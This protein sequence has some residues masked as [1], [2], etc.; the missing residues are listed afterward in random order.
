VGTRVRG[1][2]G[3]HYQQAVEGMSFLQPDTAIVML[4][5]TGHKHFYFY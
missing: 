2:E 4:S 3:P 1:E 5:L